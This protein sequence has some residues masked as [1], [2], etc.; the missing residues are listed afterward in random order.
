MSKSNSKVKRLYHDA[1]AKGAM[2]NDWSTNPEKAT[3]KEAKLFS[4]GA[5]TTQDPRDTTEESITRTQM[6]T[7]VRKINASKAMITLNWQ[8]RTHESKTVKLPK[9]SDLQMSSQ[10][11]KG[12]HKQAV[13]K[14][15]LVLDGMVKLKNDND[16]MVSNDR[17]SIFGSMNTISHSL[18]DG[19]SV[20]DESSQPN[21]STVFEKK[22]T[23]KPNRIRHSNRIKLTTRYGHFWVL[24]ENTFRR[25]FDSLASG[26]IG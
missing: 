22:M 2:L 23:G 10:A 7:Q 26:I 17:W 6:T 3:T 12:T 24:A 9:S 25:Q 16:T 13:I 19:K 15:N 5:W 21:D 1:L 8:L 20:V 18:S 11:P 14:D 4:D